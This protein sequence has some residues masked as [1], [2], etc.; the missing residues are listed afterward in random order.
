MGP[1]RLREILGQSLLPHP[2]E[3][4]PGQFLTGG[5]AWMS[6]RRGEIDASRFGVHGTENWGSAEIRGNAVKDLAALNKIEMLPW[7]EWGRMTDAYE[8]RTGADYD[9]LL[10]TLAAVTAADHAAA[11]AALYAREELSVPAGLIC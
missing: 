11:V 10:D 7:D 3:L 4:E 9:Q 8:G 1:H 2:E 6:F 5:E